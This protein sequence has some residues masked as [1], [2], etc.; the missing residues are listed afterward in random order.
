MEAARNRAFPVEGFVDSRARRCQDAGRAIGPRHDSTVERCSSGS[1]GA[2]LATQ[3]ARHREGGNTRMG[4]SDTSGRLRREELA[5]ELVELFDELRIEQ[6]NEVLAKN[7]PLETL[8]FFS[9]YAADFGE[10][11]E[12]DAASRKRLP[13]LLLL[14]YLLRLLEERLI[15]DTGALDA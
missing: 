13:N 3:L 9:A 6:I 5:W 14:G 15:D 11:H 2:V 4:F 7:V 1:R 10:A 8:E 12:I